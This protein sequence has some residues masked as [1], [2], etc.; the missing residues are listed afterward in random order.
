MDN[1]FAPAGTATSRQTDNAAQTSMQ[2]LKRNG[3]LEPVDINKI[4]RAITRCCV[5]LPSVDSLRIATKTISGLYDGATTK[6]L[7]KLSIQTAASLIFEEPEYSR[8]GARLLNQ[9]VEKEVRNQEIHSFSQSIAFGVKE[10]LIGERVAKFVIDNSRKF[11][12][13][14]DQSRNDLFEFF[15]LRTLYDRYLLKNPET[16]DVIET[17]QFFWMRVACGLAESPYEAIDLYNLFSSLEYVPSTPTL[18]NSGTRHEQLSSCFLLDSPLDSLDS[19]YKKYADVA[20]LSKFSGGIGIAYHR[21][22]S[23]GSLIRGTNGHSNGIVPWL[24]TLD[25]SVSAVNQGGKRKGACCV[26]L[27]TWHADIDDFL[28]LRDNT[29]DEA[30]R[31]HNLNLANWIPDLFMKRVQADGQWSLF[32]PK[33]V[34][35][36][37]DLYGDDFEAAYVKAEEDG[38]FMRQINARDL[39]A[40]MMRT[41][42]QT[43]NGWMTFKDACNRKSNQ[44]AL[45]ENVVHLSNLCTEIIEVTSDSETAVCNLGS[46]NASRYVKEGQFDFDKL[47]SNVRLAV[48]QLDKVID[49]NYYAIQST[50]D[51]NNRWRN[52]GLGV[53]GLQDVFFQMRLPFDS[54]EARKISAK[55]QEEIYFAAL[56]ASADLAVERGMHPAFAD[57]RAAHGDLQFDFWGVTPDDLGRWDALREKII[58]TGLRNSLMIA[59]APTA[60]IASIA[61]CY[62]CI[63]PQVSNLFKRETL[64]G[65]FVQINKYLVR[66]L[67]TAG[68]WT[69][70]I[71]NKIKL[72]EGSVQDI[73][74]FNDELKA[75]Y[76]TAWEIPMRSLI[77]MAAD[78]GAFI[79][80]SASLNLFMESPNIGKL[81]SMYMYAWQKGL[82]TTYY[83]RSRPATRIAQVAAADNIAAVIEEPKK[84][85]TDEEAL[86]CSLENPEACEACQ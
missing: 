16:R 29:G 73:D 14:I 74:A 36:F 17:P 52:I 12:D 51:S 28:E 9:Y 37:P 38:L 61:G 56:D 3:S 33:V 2:V 81:S 78:R 65:D 24:K 44:T 82:K 34:P 39:Y 69:D 1:N 27:E 71:R 22:R 41:M 58:S 45:P 59:I 13:A 18:F 47:R 6:E 46:I 70:E 7:D 54:D 15:G 10:G 20:M 85:Y 43:G 79:D 64:S 4:V 75:I 50:A 76:R 67:K 42:A 86:V 11:N 26:Y 68:L 5:N 57:T 72:S 66:E 62:E 35:H 63:E 30:R 80:Q 25:S 55:I 83:L 48:R 60:T 53:M 23:Q 8:L 19:I 40:K 49:L 31:T 21:V 84:V 77:D 32:D